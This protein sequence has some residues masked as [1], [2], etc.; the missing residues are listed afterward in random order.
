MLAQRVVRSKVIFQTFILCSPTTNI[1]INTSS[2]SCSVCGN[3]FQSRELLTHHLC[4]PVTAVTLAHGARPSPI[5]RTERQR[6]FLQELKQPSKPNVDIVQDDHLS[7]E[8]MF[9]ESDEA[10]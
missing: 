2:E 8:D 3:K 1:A 6:K 4:V 10:T 9:K 5:I 7:Q